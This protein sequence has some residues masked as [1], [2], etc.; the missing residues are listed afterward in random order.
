M[1]SDHVGSPPVFAA[2]AE[3]QGLLKPNARYETKVTMTLNAQQ[4]TQQFGS[5]ATAAANLSVSCQGILETRIQAVAS[6]WYASLNGEL[7]QA[8]ALATEWR[9]RFA[10]ELQTDVLTCV[11]HC[12]QAFATQRNII[13]NLFNSTG[14]DF[15]SVKAQLIAALSGLQGS[16]RMIVGTT[17]NYEAQLRD[18]GQRLRG[19]QTSMSQ[20]VGQIQA[21]AGD[22]QAQIT[23]TNI[24]I[25]SMTAEVIRDRQAIAEAQSRNTSGIVETIFG[26]LFAPFTGGLSLILAGIGVAS[27]VEA[28]SKVNALESTIKSYQDRIVASQQALNQDQAQLVTLNGLLVSGSIALSD[29]DVSSRMLDQVRTSWDAFFQEMSGVVSKISSAQNASVWVLEKAWFIAA[30]NEWDTIVTGTQGIIGAPITTNTVMCAYCDV[31]VVQ[32]VA[33]ASHLPVPGDMKLDAFFSG[34]NLQQAP[35]TSVLHWGTHTYWVADYMDNRMAMCMLCYDQNNRLVKQ[36][37]KSGARYMWRMVYDTQ[38]QKIV[39]TG[40]SDLM[41]SF[42]LSELRVASA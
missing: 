30:C 25:A 31:P 17:A 2:K 26:V 11:I 6:P 24:A 42:G 37:S 15:P 33:A 1:N 9:D 19:V 7:Q 4:I 27:I 40:Q 38:N 21:Q 12:G 35:N 18:W 22:L 36:V 10:S 13:T 28:Q 3:I 16:T 29:V 34:S 23:A 20:T 41:L 5:S 8:Q 39:C 32:S 14:G